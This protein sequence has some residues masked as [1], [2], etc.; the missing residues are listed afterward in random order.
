MRRAIIAVLTI[1][2]IQQVLSQ[3]S[4][5]SFGLTPKYRANGYGLDF[6]ANYYHTVTDY[7]HL[8]LVASF[9]KEQPDSTV[10]Y[11]YE[12]YLLN[13][14]Y[15]TTILTW[16]NRGFSIFFGGGVS[17]GY[18][19]IN[20]GKPEA[21]FEIQIPE[22]GFVYGVFASFELDFFLTDSLSLIV[23]V[24]GMYHFNSKVD[25]SMLLLGA[26]IRLYLK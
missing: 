12:D 8:S 16:S 3:R 17:A 22:S 2:S 4:D 6:S 15:F 11:P 1:F 13:L 5:L 25:K 7:Y 10:E 14:G 19:R 26:G 9:A 18:E 21:L 20:G 23:P 24:E